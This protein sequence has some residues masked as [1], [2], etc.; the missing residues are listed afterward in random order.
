MQ[1]SHTLFF[2]WHR[3]IANNDFDGLLPEGLFTSLTKLRVININQN[4]F[5]GDIAGEIGALA[6]LLRL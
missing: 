5:T 1:Y 4:G 2:K 3:S 6:G